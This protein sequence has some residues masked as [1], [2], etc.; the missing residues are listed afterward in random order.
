MDW[1]N[2]LTAILITVLV[3]SLSI[4][5]VLLP[6]NYRAKDVYRKDLVLSC[7]GNLEC[8]QL[9]LGTENKLGY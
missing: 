9:I 6:L 4:A 7:E 8:I 1:E 5:M 2:I 3:L